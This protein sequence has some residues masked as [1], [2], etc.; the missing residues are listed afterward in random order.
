MAKI[1]FRKPTSTLQK[2]KSLT[3]FDVLLEQHR[4]KAKKKLRV[5]MI[6]LLIEVI[7]IIVVAILAISKL[8]LLQGL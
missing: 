3:S 7:V 6:L 2:H 5:N 1:I 4:K 8:K